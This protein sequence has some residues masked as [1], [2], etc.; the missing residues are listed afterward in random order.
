MHVYLHVHGADP[1]ALK[2]PLSVP[3]SNPGRLVKDSAPRQIPP[4]GNTVIAYLDI[5]ADD[6]IGAGEQPEAAAHPQPWWQAA[7]E[8]VGKTMR[9]EATPWVVDV[10]GVHVIFSATPLASVTEEYERLLAA[11]VARWARWRKQGDGHGR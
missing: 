2:D 1:A 11:A 8:S 7:L 4:G 9:G 6:V 3:Q 5:V 10:A